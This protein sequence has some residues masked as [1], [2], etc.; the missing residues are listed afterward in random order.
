[1]SDSRSYAILWSACIGCGSLFGCNP[2]R[3][4]SIRVNEIKEPL[5]RA[6]FE[7]WNRIHRTAKGLKPVP[8]H[9][10]AYKPSKDLLEPPT[11]GEE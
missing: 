7:R 3:V 11:T 1:M 8:L 10:E 9:P 6:C 2:N 4:P 5:C